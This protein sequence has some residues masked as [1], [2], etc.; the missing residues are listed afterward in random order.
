MDRRTAN[1]VATRDPKGPSDGEYKVI[2]GGSWVTSFPDELSAFTCEL[3]L[4]DNDYSEVGFRCVAD[5]VKSE[6]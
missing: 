1:K 3:L 6:E 2:R 5:P 4:P